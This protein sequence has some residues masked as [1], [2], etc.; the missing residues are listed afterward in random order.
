MQKRPRLRVVKEDPPV[1]ATTR[2]ILGIGSRRYALDM[3]TK[4]TELSLRAPKSSRLIG[5]LR[6]GRASLCRLDDWGVK[7][8]P[9][10]WRPLRASQADIVVRSISAITCD[11]LASF[12][13]RETLPAAVARYTLFA[14]KR[15]MAMLTLRLPALFQ[16]PPAR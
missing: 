15:I 7:I 12:L 8:P 5:T 9:A 13:R 3:S 10:I 14:C 6:M 4:C 2:V 1:I 11:R 16:I